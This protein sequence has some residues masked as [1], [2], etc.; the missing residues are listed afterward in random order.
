MYVGVTVA[1]LQQHQQT[2]TFSVKSKIHVLKL[3][4]SSAPF[5]VGLGPS[6]GPWM[7]QPAT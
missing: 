1:K 3:T 6:S 4:A 2:H 5:K 7:P